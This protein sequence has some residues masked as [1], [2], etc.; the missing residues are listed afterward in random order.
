MKQALLMCICL[1]ALLFFPLLFGKVLFFGDNFSLLVPGKIFTAQHL[2]SGEFALWNPNLFLGQSWIGNINESILYPSTLIF[3]WLNP[4]TALSLTIILHTIFTGCGAYLLSK[5]WIKLPWARLIT[6]AVWMLSLQWIAT[7]D[8][9]AVNQSAALIP[10]VI[11]ACVALRPTIRSILLLSA[12]IVAQI[13]GG[14]P[15]FTLYSVLFGVILLGMQHPRSHYP[16]LLASLASA[17]IIALLLAAVYWMPFLPL[18]HASTR[19]VQSSTQIAVGGLHPLELLRVLFPTLFDDPAIGMKWALYWNRGAS[20]GLYLP[21]LL[22][23]ALW[24]AFKYSRTR[25][26]LVAGGL[27]GGSLLLA[28]LGYLGYSPL[29]VLPLFSS[30]RGAGLAIL[31]ATLILALWAGSA[32]ERFTLTPRWYQLGIRTAILSL[33]AVSIGLVILWLWFPFLWGQVNAWSAGR[34]AHGWHTLDRDR[35]ILLS[36]GVHTWLQLALC[37]GMV[38]ML[39]KK[40]YQIFVS[41]LIIDLLIAGFGRIHFGPATLYPTWEEMTSTVH[42]LAR[43]QGDD[44]LLLSNGNTP[45]TDFATYWD[46]Y[47][48]RAPYSDSFVDTAELESLSRLQTMRAIAA[49]DWNMV[50]GIRSL[51]GY[52]AFVPLDLDRQFAASTSDP[53]INTL[54]EI[55]IDHP[56]LDAY[57][58]RGYWLDTWYPRTQRPALTKSDL[59]IQTATLYEFGQTPRRIRVETGT[60]SAL[61]LT[62][63]ANRQQLSITLASPSTLLIADRFDPGWHATRNGTP[64]E[65][66]NQHGIRAIQL[67]A[68]ESK[69]DLRFEP[70]EWTQGVR[71]TLL[72][73]L[74]VGLLWIWSGRHRVKRLK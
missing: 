36:I 37:I 64:I 71:V 68:G 9:L 14:Y 15:Q 32:M 69:L 8:N 47:L 72:T 41:L 58:V 50:Y 66:H 61:S 46:A 11:L 45:Y 12:V 20:P 16:R 62:E 6:V 30:S 2:R 57:G 65:I 52:G 18:L 55:P 59:T 34:L 10:F 67:P 53:S 43:A 70:S 63:T 39:W 73:L 4:G 25:L 29:S 24:T 74:C 38:Q 33:I 48:L 54:P 60:A 5:R 26:D 23:I 40:R 44:R 19:A 51:N 49:P 22:V 13:A 42:P 7:I 21:V 27:V 3:L 31:P 35:L 1:T 56:R 17:G 28:V